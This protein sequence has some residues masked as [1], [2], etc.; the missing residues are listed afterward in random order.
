MCGIVGY[1]GGRPAG[2][3]LFD[4]LQ[5]LEYRG[6]DS[7]GI[8][9]LDG[10]GGVFL[11]KAAGRLSILVKAAG[12]RVPQGTIGIAHTRWATH[13]KPTIANA[14]PHID[15][16][17]DYLVIHNGIVENYR[18]IKD[19]LMARGHTFSS[20]TDTEIIA[21]LVEES[22]ARGNGLEEAVRESL[23]AIEGAYSILVMSVSEPD[24]I[25]AA[26][27][28]NAGGI[29]VGYGEGEMF[30]ASDLPAIVPYT[31]K[32]AF[33]ENGDLATIGPQG[34]QYFDSNGRGLDRQP[35]IISY[36]D[37]TVAKGGYKHFMLKEIMEQSQ[38]VTNTLRGRLSFDP[39]EISLEEVPFSQ[40][41][42]ADFRRVVLVG[43]GT[44]LH[45]AMVGRTMIEELA[46]VPAEVDNA[47]EFRYRN[48]VIDSST[49]VVS[50][51]QSGETVDTLAAMEEAKSKGARI[52]TI[53]NM[54]NSQATRVADHTIY[55]RAGMEIGVA[56]TKCLVNSMAA[57]YLLAACMGRARGVLDGSQMATMVDDLARL[58]ALVG[59]ALETG[60][61]CQELA[62]VYFRMNDFLYLGRG[63]NYPMALEGALKL[64]EISYSHAEGYQAG[65]MKHGPIALI[66][67]DM[68][69]VAIALKDR[70]YA[71]MLNN[72]EEVKARDG[73]VIAIATEGDEYLASR[74]DHVVYL[75]P[76]PYLLSPILSVV[77]MQLFAYYIAVRRGCDVDQPR[78]LAKSVTVE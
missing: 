29:V 24:K 28:G 47:S 67:Q 3:I 8:A 60:P 11:E 55:I 53:S 35:I 13:G 41:E 40:R 74:A 1:V 56:S 9:V 4:A 59:A 38:A 36:G 19:D 51:T 48:P 33:L 15:C 39:P 64:K 20:D 54:E 42:L 63:I 25:V 5:R 22:S 68:P 27:V 49:L 52:V 65:E 34:A 17:G 16:N 44:S 62:L 66:D 14:H 12:D 7:A 57:L 73:K 45:A 26:R 6:Y 18:P 21:H 78:N 58:P 69:V 50:L 37:V 71:K 70:L 30:L 61:L 46:R 72:I 43:M 23:G 10:E 2:P 75:P 32:V 77:P 76:V 31:H